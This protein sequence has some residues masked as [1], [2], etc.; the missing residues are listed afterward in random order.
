M[1]SKLLIL[2][3]AA[4][5]ACGAAMGGESAREVI[6]DSLLPVTTGRTIEGL[7]QAAMTELL[8]IESNYG[9]SGDHRKA[10]ARL[11]EMAGAR[12]ALYTKKVRF[13]LFGDL[14]KVSARL[15]MYP[16]SMRSYYNACEGETALPKDSG[17]YREMPV[18]QSVQADPDSLIA[19]FGDGKESGFYAMLLEV[20][21]PVAGKRKAFVHFSNVGHTFVTLIKYNRDGSIVSRSFGFYPRKTGIL[22]ATPLHPSASSVFKDDSRHEWDEAVGRLLSLQQF[23]AILRVLKSYDRRRYH[24]SHS[25]CTDF[26]LDAAWAAGIGV[27]DAIGRWPLGHGNNPGSA[28]QSLLEGKLADVGQIPS[29]GLLMI[30]NIAKFR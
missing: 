28:G 20:K 12:V 30:D 22:S 7:D 23:E 17:L 2:L 5:S 10:L 1:K 27:R 4:I 24:L 18:T 3:L 8:D 13:R 26:G 11:L 6:V 19:D 9:R 14:A 21:Q 25:N 16:L 29:D 15:R